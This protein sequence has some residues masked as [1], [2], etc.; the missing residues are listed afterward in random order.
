LHHAE[1]G[2]VGIDNVAADGAADDANGDRLDERPVALL[3]IAVARNL[4]MVG[5]R[6]DNF[7]SVVHRRGVDQHRSHDA[8]AADELQLA[9]DLRLAGE[10]SAQRYFLRP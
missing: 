9:A 6:R 3:A 8:V 1:E 4:G 7:T 2:V 10:R 5:D